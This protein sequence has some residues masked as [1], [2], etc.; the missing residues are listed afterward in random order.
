MNRFVI[1]YILIWLM[2]PAV[3]EADEISLAEEAV[4]VFN[5][6]AG[7]VFNP[8]ISPTEYKDLYDYARNPR[9]ADS[10]KILD[11]IISKAET[12]L[13]LIKNKHVIA[14][15]SLGSINQVVHIGKYAGLWFYEAGMVEPHEIDIHARDIWAVWIADQTNMYVTSI[16]IDIT[17]LTSS[18]HLASFESRPAFF[19]FDPE[20]DS[21]YMEI[22]VK[23]FEIPVNPANLNITFVRRD[24]DAMQRLTWSRSFRI[25]N[26]PPSFFDFGF[27]FGILLPASNIGIKRYR[28]ASSTI[29][30]HEIDPSAFLTVSFASQSLKYKKVFTNKII[31]EGFIGIG[32]PVNLN[33]MR[34]NSVILGCSW[35]IVEDFIKLSVGIHGFGDR[36]NNGL[37]EG[38]NVATDHIVEDDFTTEVIIGLSA[39][40]SFINNFFKE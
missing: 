33:K 10:E 16:E 40:I 3:I 39:S 19:S 31:P 22:G 18:L 26:P 14:F 7:Y 5:P 12:D 32:L 34:K 23:H 17:K 6:Q 25:F 37:E 8:Q 21:R 9:A 30:A 2:I 20:K 29:V 27:D 1:I 15:L 11:I 28:V 35:P 38:Q 36:L 4:D 13:S 24:I